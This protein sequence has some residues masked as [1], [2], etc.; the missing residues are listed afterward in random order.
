MEMPGPDS[1]ATHCVQG[2]DNAD[3]LKT[4]CLYQTVNPRKNLLFGDF[5]NLNIFTKCF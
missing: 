1:V 4:A 2:S 3:I 5:V